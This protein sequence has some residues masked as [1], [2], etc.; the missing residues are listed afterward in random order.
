MTAWVLF[1]FA[2]Q[3]GKV[4]FECAVPG[5]GYARGATLPGCVHLIGRNLLSGR[6]RGLRRWPGAYRN[7]CT[8]SGS[9]IRA[10]TS[11]GLVE[12]A[13]CGGSANAARFLSRQCVRQ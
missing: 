13:A 12:A 7:S 3:F 4:C 9:A 11:A 8:C 1:R 6:E 10:K 5:Y 2:L